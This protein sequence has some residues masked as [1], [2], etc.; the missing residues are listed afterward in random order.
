MENWAGT[1]EKLAVA[2]TVNVEW[3]LNRQPIPMKSLA[4]VGVAIS[5]PNHMLIVDNRQV[6][7]PVTIIHCADDIA[8]PLRYAQDFQSHLREAGVKDVALCQISGPHF[9][10]VVNPQA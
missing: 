2:Y 9:G 7:C 5:I 8:Y 10:S 6:N 3:F 1:P 4:K